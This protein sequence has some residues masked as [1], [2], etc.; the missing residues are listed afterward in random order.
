[1]TPVQRSYYDIE[2]IWRDDNDDYE[3]VP[4]HEL[5]REEGKVCHGS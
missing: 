3:K 4:L 1:M 5:L 2:S